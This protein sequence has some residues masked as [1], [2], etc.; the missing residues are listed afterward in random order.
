MADEPNLKPKDNTAGE[1]T[2]N[3]R[4]TAKQLREERAD[5]ILKAQSYCKEHEDD[6]GFLSAEDQ[7][8]VDEMLAEAEAKKP[9]IDQRE[10]RERLDQM[11][12]D[13]NQPKERNNKPQNPY[14]PDPNATPQERSAGGDRNMIVVRVGND[15][16][17]RPAYEK[18]SAGQKFGNAG[19]REMFGRFLRTGKYPAEYAGLQSDN[20]EQAGYL[21]ASEQ[22]ASEILREV[23]D[24]LFVRRYAKVHTLREAK[25]LGIRARTA[26][27]NTFDWS[28]EL[29][30]SAADTALKYGK[31]V[32]FP[33][34]LTGQIKVSRDLL[35]NAVI[36]IENEVRGEMAR[37]AGEVMEDAYLTGSGAQQPLGVFTAS[38]DG[39]P[40]SR[41]VNTGSAT[42]ITYEGM[43]TAKYSLKS[44]YRNGGTRAGARWLF[45]RDAVLK[46]MLLR[47]GDGHP[48]MRPGRGL[49]DDDPDT[50]LGM[51]FD[52]SE[53]APNT[54]TNGNYFGL[55]GNW[56]YYEIAD[57]LEMEVQVLMELFS[58]T[59]EVGYVGRLKTD[60]MPT[61]SEAF[62]RLK[63]AA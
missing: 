3:E 46:I 33:H 7:A 41:D 44:Q 22:F 51:P 24:L 19:Y 38:N 62:V 58:Q 10:K 49:R 34:H 47:D 53:R 25:S 43:A 32:L 30:V 54:F 37:D 12:F 31:R 52:E 39:I 14:L 29:S 23:D 20:A 57:S 36:S 27:A 61:L 42:G 4:Q 9:Y 21:V 45:H 55:L 56:R 8:I 16:T 15:E 18:I 28:A 5:L 48:L 6:K 1:Q 63:C 26:R 60:G 17:G 2:A 59:N 50:I 40:T 35:R 11:A 13:L